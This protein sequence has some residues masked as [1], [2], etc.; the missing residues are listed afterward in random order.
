M[1]TAPIAMS[2]F[3]AANTAPEVCDAK[4]MSTM[5]T[6]GCPS[7]FAVACA[8]S[9][10]KPTTLPELSLN[11]NGLYDRCVQTV[12]VPELTS[13]GPPEGLLAA[14]PLEPEPQAARAREL[15]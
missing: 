12:R 6:S 8:R 13:C 15:A 4:S 7:C 1:V 5:V 10:S 9:M 14:P 2:H 3:F 11:S